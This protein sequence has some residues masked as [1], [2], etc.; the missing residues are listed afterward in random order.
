MKDLINRLLTWIDRHEAREL[1]QY[2]ATSGNVAE[3]ERRMRT[4][5]SRGVK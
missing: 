5:E 3:L 2:L 1:E 4:W